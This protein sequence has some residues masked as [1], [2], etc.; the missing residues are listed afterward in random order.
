[1]LRRL[2][3]FFTAKLSFDTIGE[4]FIPALE[5]LRGVAILMVIGFH[6]THSYFPIGWA[7]VDL[8]FVLSGFLITRLLL[9]ARRKKRYFQN[10]YARRTLRI[11]PLYYG[12]LVAI[13]FIVPL[14]LGSWFDAHVVY[15]REHQAWF[16]TYMQN[17]F[18]AD[19]GWGE[20]TLLGHFWS[21]AIEEQF[22]L[23]WPLIVFLLNPKKLVWV[24][25]TLIIVSLILRNIY[26]GNPEWPLMPYAGTFCRMDGLAIGS[27]LA[28]LLSITSRVMLKW[29]WPALIL[30]GVALLVSV[31]SGLTDYRSEF[32]IRAGYS[33]LAFFFAALLVLSLSHPGFRNLFSDPL[34]SWFGR[35]SYGLYVIHYPVYYIMEAYVYKFYPE[36]FGDLSTKAG[37]AVAGLA[38][39]IPL[40][41]LSYRLLE[42][43]FLKLKRY[44]VSN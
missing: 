31:F 10:F 15:Y 43:P 28:V 26:F 21:L 12:S 41:L 33:L 34:L 24:C 9:H 35:Y 38:V 37:L 19:R 5:G 8:F 7:G 44:F 23:V 42:L 11:F 4:G 39:T 27:L 30:S 14:F 25:V 18:Y 32:F 2:Q 40:T 13:L 6:Y 17:W 20:S 1:M 36:R 16:W 22:Y 3:N 29:A